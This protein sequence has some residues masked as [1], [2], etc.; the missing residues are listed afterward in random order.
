M[1][2]IRINELA[3]ELEVKAHE[4]LDRLAELGV[5]EKKTYSSSI[6]EQVAA[7][8]WKLFGTSTNSPEV[9]GDADQHP[10]RPRSYP[11]PPPLSGLAAVRLISPPSDLQIKS[12][13]TL[14]RA[15]H[16]SSLFRSVLPS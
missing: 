11:I 14:W 16:E 3:R 9:R 10:A 2:K 1:N 5:T 7:K 15:M 13:P 8:L 12:P 4:I 6:D